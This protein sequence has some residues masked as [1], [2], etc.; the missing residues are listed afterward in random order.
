MDPEVVKELPEPQS[1]ID[2]VN[3]NGQVEL[4]FD[5]EMLFEEIFGGFEFKSEI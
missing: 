1:K 4:I 2:S 3:E 5:Q